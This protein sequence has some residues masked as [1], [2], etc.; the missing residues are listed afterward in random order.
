MK[1]LRHAFQRRLSP[2]RKYQQLLS[3]GS[4][5]VLSRW[6]LLKHNVRIRAAD[7]ERT[8][9]CSARQFTH[10]PIGQFRVHIKWTVSKIYFR[11][12]LLKV[13]TWWNFVV[14]EC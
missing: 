6:S 1:S 9:T 5:G 2:G 11:I 7:T 8:N 3:S 4:V 12:G 10:V 13:Q 14:F